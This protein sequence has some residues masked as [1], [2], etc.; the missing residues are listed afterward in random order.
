MTRDARLAAPPGPWAGGQVVLS[1]TT[2]EIVRDAFRAGSSKTRIP[3]KIG[4]VW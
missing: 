1:G 3:A 2:A 4:K